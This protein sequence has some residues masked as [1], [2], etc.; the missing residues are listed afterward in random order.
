MSK[1]A[2]G[3]LGVG[4]MGRRHAY[5][6]R[7]NVPE[8]ELVAKNPVLPEPSKPSDMLQQGGAFGRQYKA[9]YFHGNYVGPCAAVVNSNQPGKPAVPFP[10]SST[11]HH[12][13]AVSGYGVLDGGTAKFNGPAPPQTMDSGTGIIAFP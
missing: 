10:W 8:A 2:V 6:L 11:Y 7:R 9:C 4:E 5:N 12:T 1:V 3:V 13:L